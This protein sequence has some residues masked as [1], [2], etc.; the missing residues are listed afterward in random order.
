MK[1]RKTTGQIQLKLC[2]NLADVYCLP[3]VLMIPPFQD[4]VPFVMRHY[5]KD[6]EVLFFQ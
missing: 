5:H 4:G 3:S 2:E 6:L 1:S